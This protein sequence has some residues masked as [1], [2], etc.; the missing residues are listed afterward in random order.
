MDTWAHQGT[1]VCVFV[2]VCLY[3][4]KCKCVCVL[5]ECVFEYMSFCQCVC[6]W[7]CMNTCV[8]ICLCVCVWIHVSLCVCVNMHTCKCVCVCGCIH[9][10]VATVGML[11]RYNEDLPTLS[12]TDS[13]ASGI[14]TDKQTNKKYILFQGSFSESEGLFQHQNWQWTEDMSQSV[15]RRSWTFWVELRWDGKRWSTDNKYGRRLSVFSVTDVAEEH[16]KDGC[17]C[18]N[19]GH[20]RQ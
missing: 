17:S 5:F 13:E 9:V 6:L 15:Q 18:R 12:C 11:L 16:Q 20:A 3:E 19:R 2:C 1:C 4:Y 14:Q 7:V 8:S 10:C